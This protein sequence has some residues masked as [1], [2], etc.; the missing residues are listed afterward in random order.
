MVKYENWQTLDDTI[1]S[2]FE[3]ESK[4]WFGRPFD[5]AQDRPFNP[6]PGRQS[7]GPDADYRPLRASNCD[8]LSL[9][10]APNRFPKLYLENTWELQRVKRSGPRETTASL[11][12]PIPELN[13]G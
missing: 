11:L 13:L 2:Q 8:L 7:R 1:V 9:A 5:L 12:A 4:A 10:V 3:S 6:A